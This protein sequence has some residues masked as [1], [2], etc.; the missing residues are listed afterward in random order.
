M[1]QKFS[2]EA[3]IEAVRSARDRLNKSEKTYHYEHA[4]LT[5]ALASLEFCRDNRAAIIKA[6]QE[7]KN[8]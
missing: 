3:Q 8:K 7:T 4:R 1:S 5:A 2:I 6:M